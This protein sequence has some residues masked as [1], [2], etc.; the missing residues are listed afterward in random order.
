MVKRKI[1]SIDEELCNGCGDC[2]PACPEGAL[3][4]IDNKARLVSDLFCDGLGAC[5]GEC[6][7]GAMTVEEREAEPYDEMKVMEKI[8]EKGPNTIKA[9]LEHLK[10]HGEHEILK[11]AVTYLKENNI[12]NPLHAD[13]Q[14]KPLACGCPGTAVQDFSK[15]EESAE[16]AG[17]AESELRQ[18]P[19]QLNLV[20]PNAPYLDNSNLLIAADCV[21]FA[22][23]NFHQDFLKGKTLLMGCPKLDDAEH[24]KEKLTTIF[25]QNN[26]KSIGLVNMEVPCCFGLQHIVQ[27]AVNDSQKQIPIKQYIISVQGDIK[28]MNEY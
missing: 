25:T 17:M 28:T 15:K 12:D 9:H 7:T 13:Y 11:Q 24:Y 23:A 20:P 3:Q 18:W 16:P 22:Y 1:I 21:P 2:I 26:I 6:P 14:K 8:V 27:T 5:I 4:I 19:V 10:D